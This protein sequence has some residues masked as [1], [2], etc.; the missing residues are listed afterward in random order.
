MRIYQR[1]Y[2]IRRN[3]MT[4]MLE[5]E[6]K[7]K[8]IVK[9]LDNFII[10]Q[11]NAK[12]SVAISLRNRFRRLA[13]GDIPIKDEIYPK[14]II[15]KGPTGVGKTE[16]ARRLANLSNAPF[17]KVEAT[18]YTEIG[19]VGR[20]VEGMVRD[21][22]SEAI[23]I[24]QSQFEKKLRKQ[25]EKQAEENIIDILTTGEAN[26]IDTIVSSTE[27][28]T[29]E[30]NNE[31]EMVRKF[32]RKK[33]Q[34][35]KIEDKEILVEYKTKQN[36]LTS[37]FQI[38]PIPGM[39]DLED[40]ISNFFKKMSPSKKQHKK[41]PIHEARKIL[42]EQ[43]LENLLEF[44]KI[45]EEAKKSVENKGIIFIDEI[46]KIGKKS[47]GQGGADVSREGV[48][49]DIL[50]L[51]EGTNVKTKYGTVKTD[52]ILFIAAGAFH[53]SK[54]SDLIPE[55]QGRFPIR[56]ELDSLT[57]PDYLDILKKPKSSL[58]KQYQALLSTENV[59]LN[60]EKS[61]LEEISKIAYTLN[62]EFENIGARRLH[63]ILEKVLEPISFEPELYQ[64][65]T[66]KINAKFVNEQLSDIIQNQDL[67][68]YIL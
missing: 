19:Y 67:S 61:G 54:I 38:M 13:L 21:L 18:K 17:L 11:S 51:V 22:M 64:D 26:N 52:H 16:I 60:F 57:Q 3:I 68:Q 34:S 6:L 23:K 45:H 32:F 55:L 30:N 39:D 12:R 35:K 49:R 43:E 48:Q 65:K 10:G 44:D 4:S 1:T 7:P 37:S 9:K 29:V 28:D 59:Q 62:E 36:S 33:L 53:I 63:A 27:D 42:I 41:L 2:F 25:A 14:N 40:Q 20:D 66:V 5:Q 31:S 8:Q 47:G 56:V 50:P 24:V 58:L 46:D 15:M